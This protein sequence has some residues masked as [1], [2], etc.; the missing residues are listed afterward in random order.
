M[1]DAIVLAEVNVVA[2][3][4]TDTLEKYFLRRATPARV[5]RAEEHLLICGSCRERLDE[6]DAFIQSLKDA[7]EAGGA[8]RLTA[9]TAL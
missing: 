1:K 9:G 7:S 6:F 2:H 8:E 5:I 3:L 4:R